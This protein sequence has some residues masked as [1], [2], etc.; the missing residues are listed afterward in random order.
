[1]RGRLRLVASG[2]YLH[3]AGNAALDQL[4][5]DLIAAEN[6]RIALTLAPSA[7]QG[8]AVPPGALEGQDALLMLGQ[9]LPD[10]SIA[11]VAGSLLAVARAGVGV[12]KLDIAALT[13][14]GVLLFNAPDA[15]TEG[16]AAGA[17]ALMLAAGRRMIAIDRLTR[18]GRWDDRA[19]HRGREL[20]GKTVGIVG[21][22]R[23]G[24]ELLRLLQPF[25]V[26]ALAYSPRL[27]P[28][29]AA[30]LGADAVTLDRLMSDS[31]FVVLACPLTEE[32]R[33]MI[34]AAEIGAMK[35]TAF[36]VNVARGPVVDEAAL[37]AALQEGRIA[38]AGLDVFETQPLPGN[39]PLC[40]LDNVVL[41]PHCI[42]DTYE[43]RRDVIA[44]CLVGLNALIAGALPANIVNPEVL[45]HPDFEAKRLGLLARL[46]G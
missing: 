34:G 3:T 9:F 20:Y 41:A 17:L 45:G 46:A 7:S 43:L 27:A 44:T 33:G 19:Y 6:A 24:G 26:R 14:H 18:E 15:L 23:I 1:M 30:R 35:P 11:P 4:G 32:T 37:V 29:R 40:A 25:R 39:H 5:F 42:C 12:D 13:K 36:L 21:P 8:E 2:D 16:T 38:G 22:G 28:E 31:D 10:A